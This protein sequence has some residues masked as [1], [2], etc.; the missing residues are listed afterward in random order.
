MKKY[1]SRLIQ[2]FYN[3]VFFLPNINC[4]Y[5]SVPKTA[6]TSIKFALLEA[7]QGTSIFNK[8]ILDQYTIHN[9]FRQKFMINKREKK[10]F[11][12]STIFIFSLRE[13][14][15]RF[16][17]F[18]RDKIIGDGWPQEAYNRMAYLY[19]FHKKLDVLSCIKIIS[20]IPDF[21]S[22]IHFRS[23]YSI[24]KKHLNRN[25]YFIRFE[26]INEHWKILQNKI[27]LPD[28]KFYNVNPDRTKFN[29]DSNV[30]N[31]IKKRYY[32]DYNFLDNIG[33]D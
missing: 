6:N 5:I 30:L 19:G 28:L 8:T 22:E 9:F 31:L 27:S 20:K 21:M 16:S 23:Q 13:P 2:G 24:I 18:Y 25:S 7:E 14:A 3:E 4:S 12:S 10:Y 33:N 1:F 26:H 11:N 15:A 17:S 32:I 29:L